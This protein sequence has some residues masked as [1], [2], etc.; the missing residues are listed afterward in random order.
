MKK[1]RFWAGFVDGK[2]YINNPLFTYTGNVAVFTNR[3]SAK[4]FYQDV[5]LV[6]IKEVKQKS[7]AE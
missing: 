6:E 2:I 5:R 4:R 7:T 1:S 3:K